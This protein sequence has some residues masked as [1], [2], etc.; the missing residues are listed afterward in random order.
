VVKKAEQENYEGVK[1]EKVIWD[2]YVRISEADD[3]KV[4][5]SGIPVRLEAEGFNFFKY[6]FPRRGFVNTL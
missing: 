2:E 6:P 3:L 4:D 1:D 5:R